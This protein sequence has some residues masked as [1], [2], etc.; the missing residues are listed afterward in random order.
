MKGAG[1]MRRQ[2]DLII[3]SLNPEDVEE[4][5]RLEKKLGPTI[6]LVAVEKTETIYALEAKMAPN[7]WRRVDAV[8][9]EIKD[10]KAFYDEH[11]MVKAAKG[12]L[13]GFLINN[14]LFPKPKK[15]PIRIRKVVDAEPTT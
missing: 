6:C 8:Y 9:P 2:E 13:K 7:E 1:T 15:R 5:Q 10:L 12:W 14:N 4:I 11:E 3:A